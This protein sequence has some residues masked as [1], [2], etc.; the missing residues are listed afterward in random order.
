[1]SSNIF[2]REQYRNR[3]ARRYVREHVGYFGLPRGTSSQVVRDAQPR[4]VTTRLG[5]HDTIQAAQAQQAQHPGSRVVSATRTMYERT[6]LTAPIKRDEHTTVRLRLDAPGIW[7]YEVGRKVPAWRV[8]LTEW[9]GAPFREEA[10]TWAVQKAAARELHLEAKRGRDVSKRS[11]NGAREFKQKYHRR[12]R[13]EARQ[14]A[15]AA[16]TGD[17]VAFEKINPDGWRG[18]IAWDIW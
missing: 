18:A 7:M 8:Q 5:L 13:C 2:S 17:E 12:R 11:P 6:R 15:H 1:M 10:V 9:R 14:L 4:S 3:L 16:L